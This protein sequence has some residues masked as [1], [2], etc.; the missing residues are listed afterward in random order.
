M[1]L[2]TQ[3]AKEV[4]VGPGPKRGSFPLDHLHECDK[5]VEEYFKCLQDN[6][7]FASKCRKEAS[8]YLKCRVEHKLMSKEDMLQADIPETNENTPE[9]TIEQIK[10][11]RKE[12]LQKEALRGRMGLTSGRTE[13]PNG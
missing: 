10:Q 12:R 1:N 9:L 11:I 5:A 3:Q 4:R 6:G 2:G 7:N 13:K 8:D